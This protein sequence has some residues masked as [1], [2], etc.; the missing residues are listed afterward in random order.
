MNAG[1]SGQTLIGMMAFAE[2]VCARVDSAYALK[3]AAT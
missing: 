2:P 1:V 3:C